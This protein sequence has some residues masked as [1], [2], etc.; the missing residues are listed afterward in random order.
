M[1]REI[2]EIVDELVA[3][4]NEIERI[5]KNELVPL[6]ISEDYFRAEL[7]AALKLARLKSVKANNGS[8]FARK[9][10]VNYPVIDKIKAL[11]WAKRNKCV[12]VDKAEANKILRTKYPNMPE[13]FGIEVS[14]FISVRGNKE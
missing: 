8:I 12:A 5:K 13:G 6:E 1:S 14:E 11:A 9:E 2:N 4:Q 10:R 7:L 3:T